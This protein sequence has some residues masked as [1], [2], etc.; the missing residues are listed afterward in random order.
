ARIGLPYE[1]VLTKVVERPVQITQHNSAHQQHNVEGAFDVTGTVRTAPV[2]LIDD[3]VDSTWTVTEIGRR[4]RRA[5]TPHVHP[6]A[7]AS[8][9]GRS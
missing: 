7:L 1:A 6:V 3:I 2:L 4:L 8:T 9:S 5:G